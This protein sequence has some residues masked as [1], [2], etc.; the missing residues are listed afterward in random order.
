MSPESSEMSLWI[1]RRQNSSPSWC[2]YIS[3]PCEM[4]GRPSRGRFCLA[5]QDRPVGTRSEARY[6]GT[7]GLSGIPLVIVLA[8]TVS[9]R[10]K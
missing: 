7:L 5:R 4:A 9:L 3:C 6:R 8:H 2:L 1:V 10:W